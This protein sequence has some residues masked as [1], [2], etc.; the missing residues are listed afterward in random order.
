MGRQGYDEVVLLTGYPSFA[1]RK[2]CEELLRSGPRTLVHAVVPS[3]LE[4]DARQVLGE[5]TSEE[6]A[7][8]NL[9]EGDPAAMDLGLSGAEWRSLASEVDRIH[10]M[11]QV[12][13]L[14]AD[15]AVAERV[16]IGGAREIL[17]LGRACASLKCLVMH[18]TAHVSGDRT[19]MVLEGDLDRGQQFRNVVEE[20]LARAEKMM[21]SAM[22][23]LPVAVVR[24]TIVVGDSKTGEVDRFDGPYFLILLIVTSPPEF[25]LPLP[26]RA[27][28]QLHL[29]PVDY[30]VR[31]ACT[32]GRDPRAAGRTFHVGDPSALT[33]K[34]VFEL[35]AAAGGRRTP[36][37][38][39]ANL[40]KAILR[41]PGIDRLAKSPRA[42][43][44]ALATPVTY[45]FANTAELLADTGVRCPPFESYVEGLVEHVQHRLREKRAQESE[46]EDP[47]V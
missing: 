21:R 5:L 6:R 15:R 9:L 25:P 32:I 22:P 45:S 36:G 34:R 1:A 7:R 31:A 27:E 13:S 43:L 8:V 2:M 12:A 16:N 19:G 29:V 39:P 14:G 37:F 38:I 30:Y 10:H 46:V 4:A 47:L 33:V 44:D 20:T 11:A 35:V 3:K 40:T 23:R 24:P 17:E 41:T 18:S 26:A 28:A 42:F